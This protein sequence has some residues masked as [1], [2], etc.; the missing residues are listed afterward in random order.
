MEPVKQINS[1]SPVK[2]V[3]SWCLQSSLRIKP[4]RSKIVTI[5]ARSPNRAEVLCASDGCGNLA[6]A[7]CRESYPVSGMHNRA[8]LIVT[9]SASG[10]AGVLIATLAL[11]ADKR[12]GTHAAQDE[13]DAAPL[14]TRALDVPEPTF[15]SEMSKVNARMHEGMEIAASSDVDRDFMRMMIRHH[16]GAVDLALLQVQYV[17]DEK[18]MRVAQALLVAEG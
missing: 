13:F 10:F 4:F 2:Q 17:H 1:W 7:P 12:H 8:K 15:Y 11:G 5:T 6:T 3:N 16:Q 18:L 9:L 14:C